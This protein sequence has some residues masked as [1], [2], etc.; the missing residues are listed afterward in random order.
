MMYR[1]IRLAAIASVLIAFPT[2]VLTAAD[3][4]AKSTLATHDRWVTSVCF[5]ADGATMATA[6]GQSLLYRPGDVIVWDAKSGAQKAKLEGHSSC[7]WSVAISD[8][9]STLVSASYSGEIIVW[10]VAKKI[11]RKKLKHKGWVRSV[12]ILPDGSQFAFA[13]EDGTVSIRKTADGSEVKNIKA[14]E[15]TIFQVTFSP[16]GQHIATASA[17]KT[18]KAF[19]VA[20]GT[21]KAKLEG[22]GDAVWSVA[23]SPDGKQLATAGADRKIRIFDE[24]WKEAK[25]LEGHRDWVSQVAFSADGASLV[26]VDQGNAIRFWKLADKSLVKDVS[27]KSSVWCVAISPQGTVVAGSHKDSIRL[28]N[29]ASGTELMRDA[30]DHAPK[31]PPPPPRPKPIKVEPEKKEPAKKDAPKKDA[32]KPEPKKEPAKKPAPKKEAAKKPAPKKDAAKKP[33]AKKDAAKK[34]APKKEAAK[35]DAAKKDEPKK[36]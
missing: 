18:A 36:K 22:H 25:V 33:A 26:S 34:P 19:A 15:S 29:L 13:G 14:H 5:S 6:G 35:K 1:A 2:S 24:K 9:A 10:D 16:D 32:K 4:P 21:E 7:V 31:T 17:D 3:P 27:G 30:K 8:D 11:A 23:Y 20:D 28:W 12:D